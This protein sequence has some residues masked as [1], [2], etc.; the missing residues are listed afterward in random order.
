MPGNEQVSLRPHGTHEIVEPSSNKYA[1]SK[2]A[3]P[4][5]CIKRVRNILP[6][7]SSGTS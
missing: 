5:F 4:S 3:T 6:S 1:G 2:F 7:L